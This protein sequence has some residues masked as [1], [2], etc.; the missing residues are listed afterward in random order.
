MKNLLFIGLAATALLA[1]CSNDE[2][3]EMAQQ[4]AIGFDG[5]V[6]KST[7]ADITSDN[8]TSFKVWGVMTDGSQTGTPFVGTEVTK[9]NNT[10]GY[11]TP[12]YWENGYRYSFVALAP[13]LAP[14]NADASASNGAD[15]QFNAPN[16]V[17]EYGSI[18]FNNGDGTTDL[19]ADI[20]GTYATTP[21]SLGGDCPV[22]INFNFQ[23]LLSRVKFQFVN[24]MDDG[25][26]INVRNVSIVNANTEA[27]AVLNSKSTDFT[28]VTW[29]LDNNNKIAKL[30]FGNVLLGENEI[31]FKFG[32]SAETDHK[33]MIPA[34]SDGQVYEVEFQV[35]RQFNGVTEV[36]SHT[37]KL[38]VSVVMEQAKS[39]VFTAEL[40]AQNINP[41][42]E[43][44]PIQFN[45]AVDSWGS[46][47]NPG[48]LNV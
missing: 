39:Y 13:I 28:G 38:P 12:V 16:T 3:V 27:T 14:T 47:S 42:V 32:E 30:L 33:Y 11:N 45:A 44:C 10:W 19:I 18:I 34:K 35:E 6:N 1:G 48:E 4:N 7:R 2:T 46:F 5:F 22:P 24:N 8:F 9:N 43:L 25:S 40:N 21:I 36:Y 20:D 15:I 23:H 41:D 17:G 37:V 26:V 29:T 31:S